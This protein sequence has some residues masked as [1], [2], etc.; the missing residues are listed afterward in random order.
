MKILVTGSDGMLGNMLVPRLEKENGWQVTGVDIKQMDITDRSCTISV[1]KEIQPDLVIHAAAYTDVERAEDELDAAMA[2]NG[3]G[4]DNVAQACVETGSRMILISTDFVFDGRKDSP[5]DESDKPSPL[6]IYGRTKLSGEKLAAATL[7]RLSIVRTA[8]LYGP[9]G[10][11]FLSKV[12]GFART[13][14]TVKVVNDETGSP[15]YTRDLS[16]ALV[17]IIKSGKFKPLYHAAGS[18]HC[19]RFEQAEAMFEALGMKE[20]ELIPVSTTEFP[21]KAARP[22]NSA[23]ACEALKSEGL[24]MP[25][26]WRD[27]VVEYSRKYLSV[28]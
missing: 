11:H 2:V 28:S 25:R 3:H 16:E 17:S 21:S 5:Y 1:V 8:W 20:I 9:G 15:T 7:D 13:N 27:A 6:S 24:A 10:D 19:T 14:S 23:M 22:K 4:S 26:Q 18:G 12:F